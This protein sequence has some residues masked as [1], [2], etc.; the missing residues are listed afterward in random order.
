MTLT[1]PRLSF[2]AL[3]IAAV[4]S[5]GACATT[6]TPATQS[7][8]STALLSADAK[9]ALDARVA[10]FDRNINRGN[11]QVIFDYL[12]PKMLQEMR[13][14][15]EREDVNPE[16]LQIIMGSM[17]QGI[18]RELKMT[19]RH[20]MSQALVG[21]TGSGTPYVLVPGAARVT[22]GAETMTTQGVSL[23]LLDGGQWYLLG[24]SDQEVLTN[25]RRTYPE[26]RGVA[27]P[28]KQK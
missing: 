22:A 4:L 3:A 14:L 20:D 15:A 1:K 28:V 26:F 13:Q 12:P 27:L 8:A 24:L 19:G 10:A 11:M 7:Y 21:T 18:A 23:A 2:A 25:L 9:Q 17:L 6:G 16:V 5:L